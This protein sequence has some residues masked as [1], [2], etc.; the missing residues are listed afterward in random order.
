MPDRESLPLHFG[1]AAGSFVAL[2]V[3][4]TLFFIWQISWTAPPKKKRAPPP[5]P[6]PPAAPA[7][8]A[9]QSVENAA[10]APAPLDS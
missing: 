2:F 8:P 10:A 4:L 3:I 7:P 1:I 5:A 6:E 9:E